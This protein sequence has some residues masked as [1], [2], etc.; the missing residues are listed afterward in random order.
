MRFIKNIIKIF[1]K[2]CAFKNN[3]FFKNNLFCTYKIIHFGGHYLPVIY[4]REKGRVCVCVY[5]CLMR[6]DDIIFYSCISLC[7][8]INFFFSF[9]KLFGYFEHGFFSMNVH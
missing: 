9:Q 8:Y 7:Y 5:V 3:I 4:M 1:F 2:C 6:G